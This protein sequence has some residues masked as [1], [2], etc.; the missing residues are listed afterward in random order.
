MISTY[1]AYELNLFDNNEAHNAEN[2]VIWRKP[3][4]YIIKYTM[5]DREYA[6]EQRFIE[7]GDEGYA[8]PIVPPITPYPHPGM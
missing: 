1:E 6:Y 7:N 4:M 2:R 8:I 5:Q 3:H